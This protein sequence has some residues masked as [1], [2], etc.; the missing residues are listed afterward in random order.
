MM[1][2]EHIAL[3]DSVA[4]L[5]EREIDP[6]LEEWEENEIFPAHEVFKKLG[7]AG[8]LGVNKP[9][10]LGGMGVDYS[11]EIA[12]CEA[13]GHIRAGGVGMPSAVRTDVATPALA[14]AGGDGL[15]A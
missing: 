12:F 10:E 3:K 7:S 5:I 4:R 1:T 9:E 15:S 6:Y 8:F 13:I 11:Y 2:P 14:A